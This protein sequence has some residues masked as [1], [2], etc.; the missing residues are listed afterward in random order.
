VTR[1]RRNLAINTAAG[2]V[3][4]IV[5]AALV[6][7]AVT[8]KAARTTPQ[9]VATGTTRTETTEPK[10]SSAPIRLFAADSVWN[11]P[12]SDTAAVTP[13]SASLADRLVNEVSADGDWI[14][15]YAYSVPVYTVSRDAPTVPVILNAGTDPTSRKLAAVFKAGVPIPADATAAPGTDEHMAVLEPSADTMWEFWHMHKV[16]G[17]WHASW[18]GEMTDVSSNPG[19]FTDPSDWG[20]TATSIPLLA[21]LITFGDL[22]AG[23]IDHALAISVPDTSPEHVAPAQR[24][25]GKDTDPN[26]I[27]EG[28]EFRIRPGVDLSALHLSHL[29]LMIARAAQ[30]FGMIVRDQSPSV[31]FYGQQPTAGESSP[32]SGASGAF[33][34]KTASEIL[35][36]F[37]WRDVEVVAPR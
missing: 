14:N 6:V 34:G 36:G 24:S 2:L 4:L 26:A 27:P 33:E 28:T 37:P 20:A 19:Y 3:A 11:E 25:D 10:P 30:R 8:H 7:L 9:T 35:H 15:T 16:S 22:G 31:D 21:G 29:S 1:S 18:G 13:N 17:V 12:L 5:I 23:T 32:W